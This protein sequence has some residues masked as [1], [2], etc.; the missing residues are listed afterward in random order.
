MVILQGVVL[1]NTRDV[2]FPPLVLMLNTYEGSGVSIATGH[3]SPSS[4]IGAPSSRRNHP[5][6][7]GET[8]IPAFSTGVVFGCAMTAFVVAIDKLDAAIAYPICQMAPGLVISLWSVLYYKEISVSEEIG[9]IILDIL[10]AVTVLARDKQ[11]GNAIIKYGEK[12]LTLCSIE[13]KSHRGSPIF[14][15]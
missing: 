15:Q 4:L 1:A 8:A 3:S 14:L 13:G 6:V 7:S 11:G 2:V 12:T 10:R 9:C 5:W